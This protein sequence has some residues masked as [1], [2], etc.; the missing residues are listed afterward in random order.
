MGF[1]FWWGPVKFANQMNVVSQGLKLWRTRA[2]GSVGFDFWFIKRLSY[3]TICFSIIPTLLLCATS[4]GD[5]FVQIPSCSKPD[6]SSCSFSL[7]LLY[8]FRK[9]RVHSPPWEFSTTGLKCNESVTSHTVCE[10][11]HSLVWKITAVFCKG[12]PPF[13]PQKS[14]VSFFNPFL[15]A[16][17]FHHP[18]YALPRD[19]AEVFTCLLVPW[20][21]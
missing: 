8:L 18:V 11:S 21:V 20:S 5:L 7:F 19:I 3:L 10:F 6:P 16:Y 13:P 1:H 15:V 4:M 2:C 12:V 17:R 14:R 9:F